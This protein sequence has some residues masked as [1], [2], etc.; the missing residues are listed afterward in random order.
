M[1][2]RP[3][4][5]MNKFEQQ[6][7][8]Y[9]TRPGYKPVKSD[10]LVDKLKLS[11][12]IV[13]K[14]REALRSLIEQEKVYENQQGR[15]KLRASPD[16]IV[17]IIKR[18]A[19]GS[20]FLI[21]HETPPGDK[22][23]DVFISRSD[24]RDAHTGDEVVVRLLH[25]RR[26]GGRRCGRIEEI[27]QRATRTFVGTYFERGGDG[28][29]Q[30]DGT[31][32][33]DAISVGD[34]GAKGAQPDEKIVID[35]LRFPGPYQTG[36]AVLTEV[37][38][39]R[40]DRGVD[41]LSIIREFDLATDFP[42]KVRE[43][44]QSQVERFD[45]NDLTGRIDLTKETIV[46]IDPADARDFDDAISL[47]QSGDGGWRL[48]IH[49]ADVSHFVK[50]GTALDAEAK[51]RSTSVYLP[52]HVIGMLPEVLSNGLASLQQ[53][54]LRFT[55][56]LFIELDADGVP[57]HTEFANSVIKVTRRFSYEQVMPIIREPERFRTRVSAKVRALLAHMHKLAT[58]LRSRRFAAGAL[59][60]NLPEVKLDF[61]KQDRVCGA[62]AVE[63]DESHQIIEEFMLAANIAVA[64]ELSNRDVLFLRRVHGPP[65]L[66][67]LRALAE[68][69]SAIGYPL[70]RYQSRRDLQ[71]LLQRVRGKPAEHAINFAMLRN[72][73]R[74]EY[75]EVKM[76]H[77]ALGVENYCHFTS[78]IRRY[79][80]LVVHRLIE[81]IF[82]GKRRSRGLSESETEKLGKHCSVGERRAEA[83]ERELTKVRLLTYMADRIGEEMEAV[84]TGV[85]RF[86]FFCQGIEIPIEGLVHISAI[87]SS[88][89]YDY[90]EATFSVVGRRRGRIYRLGDRICVS[91]AHVDVDRRHLDFHIV[92]RTT[93]RKSS[94]K[95][96]SQKSEKRREK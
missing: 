50:P 90:D 28:Y 68:F 3:S 7:L 23:S 69:A 64:T 16:T 19:S 81:A 13:V 37:L 46:T 22:T 72:M 2:D 15:L 96:R 74:A 42:E 57:T 88:D 34:P 75:S 39:P 38:G 61:D 6:I 41:T 67:K 47:E 44:A 9:L 71:A 55:K 53:G 78:P 24:I 31:V 92:P 79:P 89:Y 58:L 73:K 93:R 30:V 54:K 25:R 95:K 63:H 70:K 35:M 87:D 27:L 10:K 14:H 77:Y 1:W 52:A 36:E 82:P 83:A 51:K 59:E 43:E 66:K 91:V 84:I 85:E 33:Q 86:G 18:T 20:G 62:H 12:K 5:C 32:F 65:D 4:I 76:G 29:V 40:G 48:G 45:E 60:L 94:G 8:E 17:G 80:D 56:S 26:G 21:P 49:I 11:K